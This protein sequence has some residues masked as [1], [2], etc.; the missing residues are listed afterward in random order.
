[1]KK[2]LPEIIKKVGFDF[3]WDSKKVWKLNYP[4]EEMDIKELLW[5]FDIPFHWFDGGI[6]N[7]KSKE[8][9]ENPEK[10]REEYDRT[11]KCDL[12]YPIDI[13]RNKGRWLILD[14]LHRLMKAK[15]MGL[16]KVKVRKIPRSEIKNISISN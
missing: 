7:L 9:I 1:M 14:G 4:V 2:N 12:S 8:I 3:S 5:H 15:I 10:Y 13:M 11:M 6:Y 16:S